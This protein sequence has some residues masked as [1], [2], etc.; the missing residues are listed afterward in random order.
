MP[1]DQDKHGIPQLS[2]MT[3]TVR[4]SVSFGVLVS[5]SCRAKAAWRSQGLSGVTART[6]RVPGFLACRQAPWGEYEG[7]WPRTF[8]DSFAGATRIQSRVAVAR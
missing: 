2:A 6:S 5:F 4:N 1:S 8:G 7:R 3:A